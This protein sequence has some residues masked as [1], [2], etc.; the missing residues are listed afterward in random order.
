MQKRLPVSTDNLL[1]AHSSAVCKVVLAF[2]QV[3]LLQNNVLSLHIPEPFMTRTSCVQF[4]KD[5]VGFT[6]LLKIRDGGERKL[7]MGI[8]QFLS[9]GYFGQTQSGVDHRIEAPD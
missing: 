9:A 2:Q 8:D 4:G 7:K 3:P 6:L 1:V 5:R